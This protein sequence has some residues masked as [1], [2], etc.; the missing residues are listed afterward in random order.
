MHWLGLAVD[1]LSAARG[2][3]VVAASFGASACSFDTTPIVV[4][5]APA[6]GGS[7]HSDA[8][9]MSGGAG[10]VGL[11]QAGTLADGGSSAGSGGTE[12][13]AGPGSACTD[14]SDC[15]ATGSFCTTRRCDDGHCTTTDVADGTALPDQTEGDCKTVVCDGAGETRT[16][17]SQKDSPPV[18]DNPCTAERCDGDT[19]KTDFVGRG[20]AC[21]NALI[22]DGEGHC[23]G[24]TAAEDCP[25][26]DGPCGTRSCDDGMCGGDFLDPGTPL[27][28]QTAA[29]CQQLECDG[30]G[31]IVAV[32]NDAD[33]PASEHDCVAIACDEG[34]PTEAPVDRGV[35]C[36]DDGG[37]HCDG[38]GACV[39]CTEDAHCA[40]GSCIAD[41][42]TGAHCGDGEQ[43]DDETDADCGGGT[44]PS[45][46]LGQSCEVDGDCDSSICSNLIC[47]AP[48]NC[49]DGIITPPELC[50][51]QNRADG[52]GCDNDCQP[53]CGN[54][55]RDQAEIC[56][57]GD[58]ASGDGCSATCQVEDYYQCRSA[59]P[60]VCIL[61]EGVCS[62]GV[63]EDSDTGTDAADS[64]CN[65]RLVAPACPAG[66]TFYQFNSVRVPQLIPDLATI[67]NDIRVPAIGTVRRVV[68]RVNITHTWD[69]DL[70]ISLTSPDG[71]ARLAAE[72]AGDDGQ[73]F[74]NTRFRDGAA[75]AIADGTAPFNGEFKPQQ[76]FGAFN[77]EFAVGVWRLTIADLGE[78]D[79]G[80]LRGYSLAICAQ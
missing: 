67:N 32:P 39:Q 60:S 61:Q 3:V 44:C 20:G 41:S 11:P 31:N 33:T 22:C 36:D 15:P 49:G 14:A 17:A 46:G 34:E 77:G 69:G 57:D 47:T 9:G 8:G 70:D 64:D 18:D 25:G 54:G 10:R 78:E 12:S 42:C 5:E 1:R 50:D 75:T 30:A 40:A 58:H 45:C 24:C 23:V 35:A 6:D 76:G 80:V 65:L 51:D 63:N 28:D 52:D 53:S 66:Q 79:T 19:P 26:S 72:G 7:G 68:L 71:T 13:D 62:G 38:D 43:N 16:A 74:T 21:G 48:A 59:F 37:T 56:D 27:P 29:D 2:L 55:R 73:N 4:S